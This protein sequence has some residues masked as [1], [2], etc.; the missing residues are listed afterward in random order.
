MNKIS[1]S[2]RTIADALYQLNKRIKTYNA[3][4]MTDYEKIDMK[5]LETQGLYAEYLK[6]SKDNVYTGFLLLHHSLGY[7]K[8]NIF[9]GTKEERLLVLNKLDVKACGICRKLLSKT[10]FYKIEAH[11]DGLSFKCKVCS[12]EYD[13]RYNKTIPGLIKRL[14]FEQTHSAKTRNMDKQTYTMEWFTTWCLK[15]K[16]FHILYRNWC[17]SGFLTT[18]KPSCDRIDDDKSY[19]EDNIQLMT[20][21]E[22]R[23]KRKYKSV[24][25]YSTDGTFER[26]FKNMRDA[27]VFIKGTHSL[28]RYINRMKDGKEVPYKGFVWKQKIKDKK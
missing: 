28:S 2:K 16:F 7:T 12:Y 22:N 3:R 10:K 21:G 23:E 14:Y 20:W 24:S 1:K 27:I 6:S 8:N 17:Q 19:T 4:Y 5:Y 13:K 18:L 9:V 25:M 11:H 26:E 15:Q